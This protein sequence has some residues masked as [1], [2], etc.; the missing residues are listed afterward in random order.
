MFLNICEGFMLKEIPKA[1]SGYCFLRHL[2]LAGGGPPTAPPL[3]PAEEA[4]TQLI[5]P[6]F[7]CGISDSL[8]PESLEALPDLTSVIV[9]EK[10]E[11]FESSGP[12]SETGEQNQLHLSTFEEMP[13]HSRP[14]SRSS[15][16]THHSTGTRMLEVQEGILSEVRGI[17]SALEG[18][19]AALLSINETLLGLTS[20]L[21][22]L[23]KA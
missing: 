13:V 3:T 15:S 19:T 6:A 12:G 16:T 22:K 21:T 18:Q 17:R 23:S 10:E 9:K 11:P 2:I 7:V 14:S 1:F 4:M 8:P 5:D 20:A